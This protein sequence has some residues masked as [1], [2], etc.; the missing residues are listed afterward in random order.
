MGTP[1]P[2]ASRT[3]STLM[4]WTCVAFSVAFIAYSFGPKLYIS[5]AKFY[6]LQVRGKF[7]MD[8]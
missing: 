3:F 6:V 2:A 5:S 4:V 1:G 7:R 8:T